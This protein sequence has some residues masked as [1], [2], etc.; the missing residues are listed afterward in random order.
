V[1]TAAIVRWAILGFVAVAAAGAWVYHATAGGGLVERQRYQCPMH[2]TVVQF[3]RGE[4]PVCGMDLVAVNE[5]PAPKGA[6]SAGVEHAHAGG[7]EAPTG[8]PLYTCP[9]HP[10]F[11]TSDPKA[12]CPDCGMKL[13]PKEPAGGEAPA[14]HEGLPGVAPVELTAERIQLMGLRTAV[15]TRGS[16]SPTLRTV[17]FVTATEGGVESVTTRF[18]GWVE[19][20]LVGET[21]QLVEKGQV[22]ATVY[23]PDVVNAQQ[24]YLN[25]IRWTEAQGSAP[26]PKGAGGSGSNLE[27]DAR[28]RLEYAGI[29]AQDIAI[30]ARSGEAQRAVNIRAPV[31]GYVARKGVVRGAYVQPGAELYQI[32][33]LSTVWVLADVYESELSRVKVGQRA[34][35]ELPAYPGRQFVGEVQFL[36]PALNTGSRTL[37]ARIVLANPDLMLRP[38]MYGDVRLEAEAAE[39]V[40]IPREALVDTGDYQYVFVA[41]GAGR[42][43]PR[44]VKA[45]QE[46][47][48]KVEVVSGLDEGERVVTAANFL[49]DSESRLRAAL[50]P[51]PAT[52]L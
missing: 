27:R 5:G 13:S 39:A 24:V 19:K 33:D 18:T 4:C 51:G 25:A 31:R 32:A 8:A 12:R 30:I 35:V 45:G 44:R 16:R 22:L 40:L 2:P 48:G 34:T 36:Y 23:S 38:G 37:Q 50:E 1:H 6:A 28:Q 15:A 10:A 21:G 9:M 29:A 46:G 7:G 41:R 47:Q 20:V 26:V 42:F 3:R 43:E 14:A 49:L 11:V 17:G 52:G